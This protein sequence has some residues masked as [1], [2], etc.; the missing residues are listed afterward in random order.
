M[1]DGSCDESGQLQLGEDL[2]EIQKV[3]H[4]IHLHRERRKRGGEREGEEGRERKEGR[5]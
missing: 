5:E 3:N 1:A 4:P 2:R